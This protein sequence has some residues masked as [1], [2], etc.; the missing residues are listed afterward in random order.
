MLHVHTYLVGSAGFELAAHHSHMGK[1]FEGVV[2]GYG[3][4]A[5]LPVGKHTHLQPVAQAAPHVAH[6]GAV[7]ILHG[8][9]HHR[10]ILALG[11]FVEKLLAERRFGVGCFCHHQKPGSVFVDA[12]HQAH[13][14]VGYIVV[15]V[16]FK[17]PCKGI[18]QGA[19]VVAVAGMHTHAGGLIHHQQRFVFI[20]DVERNVLRNDFVFVAWSV[21]HHGND[22]AGVHAIVRL[23]RAS[24]HAYAL[25]FGSILNAV[26]RRAFDALHQILVDTQ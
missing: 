11:G 22:F 4:L 19:V 21:H 25:G 20:H 23:H 3:M 12:M 14:R 16:V 1:V 10:H 18:H 8:A 7:G 2:M 9:P 6:D 26:A 5:V 24:V 17:V 15:G 13:A